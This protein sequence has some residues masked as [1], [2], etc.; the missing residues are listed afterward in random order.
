M[1]ASIGRRIG[2]DRSRPG[3]T[4]HQLKGWKDKMGGRYRIVLVC[5]LTVSNLQLVNYFALPPTKRNAFISSCLSIL[6]VYEV[7]KGAHKEVAGLR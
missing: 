3:A 5:R 7:L 2:G 4:L 1:P 6:L